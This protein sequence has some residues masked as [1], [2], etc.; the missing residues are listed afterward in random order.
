MK[1]VKEAKSA[2]SQKADFT[3]TGDIR[4]ATGNWD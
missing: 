4:P 2:E 1:A 3:S